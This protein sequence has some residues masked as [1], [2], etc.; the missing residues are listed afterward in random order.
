MV[1]RRLTGLVR[2]VRPLR[3][4][5]VEVTEGAGVDGNPVRL[6]KYYLD[7][8]TGATLARVDDCPGE[9]AAVRVEEIR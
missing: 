5:E 6:V 1:E 7:C 2:G 3:V 4:L 9:D 8:E